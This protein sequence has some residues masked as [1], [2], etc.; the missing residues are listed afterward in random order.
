MKTLKVSLKTIVFILAVTASLNVNAST[1]LEKMYFFSG[2]SSSVKLAHAGFIN[3]EPSLQLSFENTAGEKV[4]ITVKDENGIVVYTETF[5]G[6]E[7]SKKYLFEKE[8]A[9]ANPV[10][11]VT[12]LTSKKTTTYTVSNR[13]TTAEGL[14]ITKQ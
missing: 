5:S 7:Y 9:D 3:N 10:I 11:T 13:E 6:A 4:R 1:G 8:L 2:N 14:N 12:Y